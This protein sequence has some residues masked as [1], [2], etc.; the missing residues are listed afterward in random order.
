VDRSSIAQKRLY[1]VLLPLVVF[2]AASA[3]YAGPLFR[4]IALWGKLDWDQ[5]TFWNAVPRETLLRYHQFP[6]WN[7]FSNGG[8]VMLAMPH[9]SFLSPLYLGVLLWGPIA[10]LKI[11]WAA[12]LFIGMTGM[13]QVSKRLGMGALSRYLP[14]FIFMLSSLY[15]LHLREGH[16]EWMVLGFMP[17]SYVFFLRSRAEPR[18]FAFT[19]LSLALMIYSGGVYVF[20]ATVVF[21]AAHALVDALREKKAAPL[22][23]LAGVLLLVFLVSAAKVVPMLEL[24]KA[25][26]RPTKD[27][28]RLEAVLI[29]KL[30]LLRDQNALYENRDNIARMLKLDELHIGWHRENWHEYGV[31][32]G[33]IPVVL[34]LAG[35][36]IHFKRQLPLF[37]AGFVCLWISMGRSAGVNLWS[38]LHRLPIYRSLH[39]PSRYLMCVLFCVAVFAGLGCSELEKNAGKGYQKWLLAG[40]VLAVFLDLLAVSRPIVANTFT[41]APVEVMRNMDFR[42]G[43]VARYAYP[44]SVSHSAM[45]PALLANRGTIDSYDIVGV[46]RGAVRDSADAAY[47]GEAYLAEGGGGARVESFSPNRISVAVETNRRDMLVL[48]QNFHRGWRVVTGGVTAPAIAHQGLI[49]SPVDQGSRTVTFFFRPKSFVYGLLLTLLGLAALLLFL[50]PGL[51]K[52]LRFSR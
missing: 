23:G 47:R 49:A 35:V 31:Y 15:S 36:L 13:H 39:V 3:V 25:S 28:G 44:E 24:L 29:P 34:A 22:L 52:R 37:C 38:V 16:V 11:A 50:F 43:G 46:A 6:L 17:W 30:F 4:D 41:L 5:F 21:F 40:I 7:P 20:S 14:P 10:G 27:E 51:W 2:A 8:N 26:P 1:E 33:L 19:V 42:Q 45:Y 48:N 32:T 12:A 9:S 18:Y